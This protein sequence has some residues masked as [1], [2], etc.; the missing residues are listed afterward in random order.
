MF[1]NNINLQE[2]K[3]MTIFDTF[4]KNFRKSVEKRKVERLCVLRSC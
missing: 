3:Y 1:E 4:E 2:L